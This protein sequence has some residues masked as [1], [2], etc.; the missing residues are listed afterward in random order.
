MS[1]TVAY[2]FLDY[3]RECDCV[4]TLKPYEYE[5]V[6][7]WYQAGK[8]SSLSE[9]MWLLKDNGF[10]YEYFTELVEREMPHEIYNMLNHD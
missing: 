10:D 7:S 6:D 1:N 3:N 9:L 8:V 2:V 4:V 5:G